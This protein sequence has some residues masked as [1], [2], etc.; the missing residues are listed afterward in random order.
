MC[1]RHKTSENSL[2]PVSNYLNSTTIQKNVFMSRKNATIN[3]YI[4]D[5]MP[6]RSLIDA[7]VKHT[8]SLNRHHHQFICLLVANVR[9]AIFVCSIDTHFVTT[10]SN[11]LCINK[12]LVSRFQNL[13]VLACVYFINYR[14]IKKCSLELKTEILVLYVKVA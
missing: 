6:F 2:C 8:L 3:L 7:V 1:F 9:F 4:N 12:I 14:V 13:F 11:Q 5:T 10:I